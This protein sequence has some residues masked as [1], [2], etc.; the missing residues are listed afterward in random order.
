[1]R[2]RPRGS[3]PLVSGAE[4]WSG[5]GEKFFRWLFYS[6]ELAYFPEHICSGF[7]KDMGAAEKTTVRPKEEKMQKFHTTTAWRGFALSPDEKGEGETICLRSLTAS[8]S[9]RPARLWTSSRWKLPTTFMFPLH[10]KT[11]I[12]HSIKIYLNRQIDPQ[13][14]L[15]LNKKLG[16]SVFI[17]DV[18]TQI[19]KEHP[20]VRL[21]S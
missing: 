19:R 4:R 8:I 3:F 6:Q 17:L 2:F 20:Y 18:K 12:V 9:L 13:K 21:S 10:L 11:K 15:Y 5:G 7:A 16:C 1:M 14:A